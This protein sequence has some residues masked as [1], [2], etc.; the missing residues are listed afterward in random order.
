MEQQMLKP[1]I[2]IDFLNKYIFTPSDDLTS[3]VASVKTI[4]ENL[5]VKFFDNIDPFWHTEND[6]LQYFIQYNNGE[7]FCQRR[8]LKYDFATKTSYWQTYNLKNIPA[9][10]INQLVERIEAFVILNADVKKFLA[11]N[12]VKEVGQESLF[13][14]RRLLKKLAEKNSML[15]AS[16]WRV[17]PDVV[18]TYPGEK[19]M[20]MKWRNTLRQ[21]VI[22]R[23]ENFENPLEFLKYLYDLKYPVDP[24][25]YFKMYP[26]GKDEEGNEVEYLST[27]EQWVRYDVEA[28]TDF[29][30]ANAVRVLNYT[31][32]YIEAR[33]RVKKNILNVLKEFDVS[34]IYPEY[35]IDK[36]EEETAE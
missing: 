20:W 21:E 15:S 32:G 35:D 8:K 12:E 5:L 17:L 24:K 4:D 28:S 19:D 25:L 16:D 23:P 29:I 33:I 7:Y 26:E 31:K 9:D 22:Q 34:D 36:F 10:K 13:Y 6:Q 2:E 18:D 14:E 30:T 3:S 27:P 11:I 1:N